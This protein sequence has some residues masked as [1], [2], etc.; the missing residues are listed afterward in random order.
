MLGPQHRI[1]FSLVIDNWSKQYIQ[2]I[3][4]VASTDFKDEF[5]QRNLLLRIYNNNENLHETDTNQ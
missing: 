3:D 2:N 5:Q 4:K 1:A